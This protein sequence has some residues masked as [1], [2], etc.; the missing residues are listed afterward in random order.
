MKQLTKRSKKKYNSKNNIDITEN[1]NCLFILQKWT[2]SHAKL[3]GRI[4]FARFLSFPSERYRN[5]IEEV[6]GSILFKK[7][8]LDIQFLSKSKDYLEEKLP[9]DVI[10]KICKDKDGDSFSIRYTYHGF[11]RLYIVEAD[12]LYRIVEN[13]FL[14]PSEIDSIS[15]YLYKLRRINSRNRLTHTLL[16]ELIRY[17]RKYFEIGNPLELLPLTQVDLTKCLNKN[18]HLTISS[19]SY[20]REQAVSQLP[21]TIHHSWISRLVNRIS[22]LTP[23]GEKRSLCFFFPSKTEL[24]KRLLKKILD[25]ESE[26]PDPDKSKIPLTDNRIANLFKDRFGIYISRASINQYRKDL[27]IPRAR[28][29]LLNYKYPPLS[30]NFS[31]YYDLTK[32]SIWRNCPAVPGVYE[33]SVKNNKEIEHLHGS[34]KV[35]YIGSTTNIK[36]RLKDHLSQTNKNGDIKRF[37]KAHQCLFRYIKFPNTWKEEE[38]KLLELFFSTYGSLPNSNKLRGYKPR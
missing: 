32:E 19:T 25:E 35:F 6:E 13:K 37:L 8:P 10:A 28:R 4:I 1:I 23:A 24:N 18:Y 20:E 30:A 17:Q 9:P 22:L 11:N 12:K 38:R 31:P 34:A 3:I 29:R 7:L 33:F 21:V 5:I 15:S 27:G 26:W 2:N 16:Q 36:K 14:T